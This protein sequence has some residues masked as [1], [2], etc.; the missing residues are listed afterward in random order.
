[1]SMMIAGLTAVQSTQMD[2]IPAHAAKNLYLGNPDLVDQQVIRIFA[3][4]PM[5]SAAAY[6]HHM[7]REFTPPRAE[8]SYIENLL[9]MMGHVDKETGFPN[10]RYVRYFEKLWTCLADHEMTCSTAALLQ[11]A[12]GL[13]DAISSMV[14]AISAMYGPLHGGAI[15]V[16]YKDIAEIGSTANVESKLE[17][18][19]SGK[20]RLYGYGHRVYRVTDPRSVHIQSTLGELMQEISEDPLLKVAFELN[21]VAVNDEYFT[22]RKLKPNADLFAAFTYGAMYVALL[23]S[24][25][26][27]VID[28]SIGASLRT[29]S[30]RS[31]SLREPKG[32]WR[33]G[34]KR[35]VGL[36]FSLPIEPF[37]LA[38]THVQQLVQQESGGRGRSTL[39]IWIRRSMSDIV[40]RASLDVFGCD[41]NRLPARQRVMP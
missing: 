38:N 16:A 35:C 11:T 8:L 37:F 10:P 36:P 17:R 27:F 20:E 9:L 30:C 33:T 2:T 31:R 26:I 28:D 12:S 29:S 15:E 25:C 24:P 5:V 3:C 13:P 39:V 14:S 40:G 19:R 41:E 23:Y 34:K 18:V 4:F 21:R 32:S 7:G 1:M 6:C 22:S